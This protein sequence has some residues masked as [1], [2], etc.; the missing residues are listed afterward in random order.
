MEGA[1]ISTA[2]LVLTVTPDVGFLGVAYQATVALDC[3]PVIGMTGA[4][5]SI[6]SFDLTVT[7]T[8]G[9]TGAE[10]YSAAFTLS[11]TPS[12]EMTGATKQLP[13]PIPWTI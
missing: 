9:M 6:A 4:G 5:V 13:H 7:P 2:E 10:K 11:V 12:L 8:I 1:G 3:T